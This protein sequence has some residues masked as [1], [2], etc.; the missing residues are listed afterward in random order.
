[1]TVRIVHVI[2][3]VNT[4]GAQTLVANLVEKRLPGQ[5]LFL[6]VL[7]GRGDLSARLDPLFDG[8]K[9]LQFTRRSFNVFALAAQAGT[10]LREVR[11]DVIHSH[12]LQ[13]DLASLLSVPWWRAVRVTTV[14]AS[15]MEG[16]PRRS[17]VLAWALA[18]VSR[19]FSAA[20]ACSE[21]SRDFMIHAGYAASKTTVISNGLNLDR[22]VYGEL[23]P[24]GTLLLSLGRWHPVKDF[25]TLFTA[26]RMAR[27]SGAP[28]QLACAG[29]G[30]DAENDELTSLIEECGVRDAVALLG[31]QADVR[32]ALANA[33]ALVIASKAEALPMAGIEALACAVPV[34]CTDVG[35]C[36][37]L[38]V[39]PLQLVPAQ[40]P[41]RFAEAL[42]ALYEASE[43]QLARMRRLSRVLAETRY[44]ATATA[45]KY[46]KLYR[47]C[48]TLRE[49]SKASTILASQA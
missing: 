38:V 31:P 24:E 42:V 10:Y 27:A 19:S 40:Q 21:S 43:D 2:N 15:S 13:S 32:P 34:V 47:C 17:R 11:A 46:D 25:A 28:W 37:D 4:G 26:L 16:E 45:E 39:S 20:V 44:D 5:E 33:S 18:H 23:P 12:L 7:S 6:L 29:T 22:Y 30:M 9:Y 8:V 36:A 35:S 41:S 3:D 14:H 1:M 49:R 48:L